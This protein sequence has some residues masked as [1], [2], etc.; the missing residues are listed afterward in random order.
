MG[1][2]RTLIKTSKFWKIYFGIIGGFLCLLAIGLI[3]FSVW[4]SDYENSQN[5]VEVDKVL[6]L[7]ENKQYSEIIAKTD[8]VMTGFA[9]RE[10]YEAKLK[11]AA[12]GKEIT[13]VKAFSYDRF[14]SPS[15]IIRADGEDLCKVTLKQSSEKSKFGFSLYEFDYISEFSFA[16]VNVVFLAP[17]GAVPYIDGKAVDD[18]FRK[19]LAK[20]QPGSSQYTLTS[21]ALVINRYEVCGLL[22]E[23]GSVEVRNQEGAA[24]ALQTNSSNE[25]VAEPLDITIHAPADFTVTVNGVRLGAQHMTGQSEENE[26]IRYMLN[27]E[28]KNALSLFNTYRVEQLTQKPE[29]TVEDSAGNPI[30]CT[31]NSETRTF[32]VGFKVF[33]LQIPSNYTVVVN[34]T[35]ITGSENWLAEK[36]QEITEL[37]NIPEELFAKPY[38]NL[39]K[40]AVLSG[41][42]E[43]EAKN[44]AGETVPLEYDES[45]MTY[46]GNFAVSESI[47]GEYTQIA[48]DGAK[49]YAG[50]MSNDISMSSFLSRIIKGTQMYQDMS[51]YRQYW[52]TD[53]DSTAFENVEAY[54]LRVYGENCFSCAVYFDYWIY[55]QR[56]KPDFQ[57]KLETNTRIWYVRTNGSWYMADI[58]IFDRNS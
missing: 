3:V 53:H 10:T 14:A 15:Y 29:V 51:E 5:T 50:F 17:E 24:L 33:T 1:K 41:G 42:L 49:T 31:Y 2:L 4:L 45:S 44:F 22:S 11:E 47:Q 23:P 37:K 18:I 32:D 43:I 7:F 38:M 25:I 16:E 46:S 54:D 21:D 19:T 26:S 8:V 30:E 58:E 9:D 57:Q 40:V 35:E 52:Y 36:N 34:G 55:G 12:E 39:Y 27:E 20:D 48:I 6:S 28:D 13:Y 56:G